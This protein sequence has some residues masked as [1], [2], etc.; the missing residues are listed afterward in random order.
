MAARAAARA[1]ANGGM[2][3]PVAEVKSEA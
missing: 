3:T 1:A 2:D